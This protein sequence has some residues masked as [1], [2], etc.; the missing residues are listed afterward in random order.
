MEGVEGNKTVVM[1]GSSG[2]LGTALTDA[3]RQQGAEV[4]RLVRREARYADEFEWDPYSGDIDETALKDVDI[5][6]NLA[7]ANI[8]DERWTDERRQVLYDSRITTTSF[9]A[10]K[11]ASLPVLPEV[12]VAQSAIGIYGDRGDEILTEES[13]EG[14]ESDFLAALTQD[15][16]AAAAPATEVGIRVV[17]PRTGLVLAPEAALLDRLE[18]L[19]KAGLGGP[20]GSGDQWWSW[21]DISDVTNALLFLIEND[22]SGPFNITAPS[23]VRQREFAKTMAALLNRPS[24]IPAPAF[25]MKLVLGSEKAEAIGLSSTRAVPERLT[26]A[27]FEF[28]VRSVEQSLR[29]SLG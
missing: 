15:W 13:S 18:P 25:A 19:F 3:L 28:A 10:E 20:L 23:P 17:H 5:V 2:L 21:V 12:F 24:L 4:R 27:G 22:V 8:G 1:A 7:G 9:L 26:K 16:E 14:P 6:I 29:R 11:T